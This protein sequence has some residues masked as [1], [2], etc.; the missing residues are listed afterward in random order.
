MF[1]N[2]TSKQQQNVSKSA[3]YMDTAVTIDM[4]WSLVTSNV[5]PCSRV[6]NTEIPD[7]ES[8]FV[9]QVNFT[10]SQNSLIQLTFNSESKTLPAHPSAHRLSSRPMNDRGKAWSHPALGTVAPNAIKA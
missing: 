9:Q 5:N 1:T 6:L 8:L 10:P 3:I 7:K 2:P 4:K